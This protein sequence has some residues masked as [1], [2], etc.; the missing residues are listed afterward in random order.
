MCMMGEQRSRRRRRAKGLTEIFMMAAARPG[1]RG[2]APPARGLA[3]YAA[4]YVGLLRDVDGLL[5]SDAAFLLGP[6]LASARTLAGNAT[7]CTD[8]VVGDF[9][10]CTD[11]MEWNARAQLTTW[12]PVAPWH[13]SV[14]RGPGVGPNDYARK[15]WAGLVLGYYAPRVDSYLAQGLADAAAARPLDAQAM[16]LR[17]AKL[18]LAWQREERM[19]HPLPPLVVTT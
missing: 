17:Q 14:A 12:H 16:D 10:K 18:A 2:R 7:D 19:R 8:T 1:L 9:A 4:P 5:A 13:R 11:F 15:Q 6:W 3:E